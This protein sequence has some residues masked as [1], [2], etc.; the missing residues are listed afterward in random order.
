M[1]RH[2]SAILA[3]YVL[4][5]ALVACS[6]PSNQNDPRTQAPLM[7]TATVVSAMDHAHA[8][9]GVMVARIQS[10]LSFRVQGKIPERLVDVDTVQKVK[11][12][13]PL[14]RLD[15]THLTRTAQSGFQASE[16]GLSLLRKRLFSQNFPANNPGTR[17]QRMQFAIGNLTWQGNHAAVG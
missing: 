9:T 12:G 6:E 17:T 8:F 4:L 3:V 2:K 7:R 15:P 16:A 13:Q 14:M 1:R 5:L 11:R 10:D